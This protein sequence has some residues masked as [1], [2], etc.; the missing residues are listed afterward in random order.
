L[1]FAA[2]LG[3]CVLAAVQFVDALA[4]ERRLEPVQELRRRIGPEPPSQPRQY[5]HG[6]NDR[7]V[8]SEARSNAQG[9]LRKISKTPSSSQLVLCGIYEQ[10]GIKRRM[11]I[12]AYSRRQ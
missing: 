4:G 8:F 6:R 9:Q 5:S 1:R 2:L 11:K 12:C 3:R 7:K 10:L